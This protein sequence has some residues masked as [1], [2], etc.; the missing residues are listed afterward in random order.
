MSSPWS[1]GDSSTPKNPF[2]EDSPQVDLM[3][4]FHNEL[5]NRN[6]ANRAVDP[7]LRDPVSQSLRSEADYE[8]YHKLPRINFNSYGWR[9]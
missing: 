1:V 5:N 3:G 6:R 8:N 9:L 7:F 2:L 4:P